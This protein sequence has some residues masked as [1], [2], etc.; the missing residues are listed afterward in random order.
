MSDLYVHRWGEGTRVV[1]VHGSLAT[2]DEEWQMQ[3]PL[4]LEGYRLLAPDRRGYGRSPSAEGEDFHRDAEDIAELMEDGAHLVGHS[5]GGLGAMLAA[6]RRPESTL[7]L[8]LLEPA[9]FTLG[10]QHPAGRAL[11]AAVRSLWD[12]KCADEE[13]LIRFLAIVGSELPPEVV[14]A[15]VPLVGLVRRGRPEW[16]GELP[17]QELKSATFPKLIV[18]GGHSAG[19]DA[20]CDELA[21]LLGAS[22]AEAA[23]AAHEVQ[24]AGQAVN[25]LLLAL[26][27]RR[28]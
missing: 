4:A 6:A 23:G 7:S 24:F 19:F 21:G 10:Q 16:Q 2:G 25:E 18:S 27:R 22:R 15:L 9:T 1:L 20:M 8:T 11:T 3:R 14:T 28:G 13:W 17:I 5:Y 12:V 26:W